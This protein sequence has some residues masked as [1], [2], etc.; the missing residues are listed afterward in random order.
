[1]TRWLRFVTA[2]SAA[3][4]VLF[5]ARAVRAEGEGQGDLD[6]ALRVKITANG[7]GDLNK[8]IELLEG[9]L[10]KGL[11]VENS[12]FA[13][14]V[15]SGSLLERATQ[16][17]GVVR[18]VP[19]ESLTDER[20]QRIRSL[21]ISDL[22]RVL[23]YDNPPVQATAMLAEILALPGGD[24][25]EALDLFNK[26]IDGE[27]FATMSV[28]EQTEALTHRA[29]LQPDAAKALADFARAVELAPN[30][31]DLRLARAQ[32]QFDHEDVDGALAE[33]AAV[34]EKTPNQAAAYLLQA[35]ILRTLKR[36]D[37][38]LKCLDKVAELAPQSPLPHMSRGEIF[39]EQ[40]QFEKA[41]EAFTRVLELQP[42]MDLALI[43]RAEAYFFADKLDE[44]LADVD[45]VLKD[46]PELALAH[47]LRAQV[48]AGKH[49]LGEAI[50][51]M[52]MLV[53]EL[54]GQPDVRMHLALYYQPRE[55]I[56]VYGEVLEID[57]DN[58]LALRS[59]GDAQLTVGDHAAAIAD[60]DRALK[61]EPEDSALLNNL[62]WVLS[63]SP[64]DKL[65]DGK[66]AIEL[67]TKAAE[68]TEF[69]KPHI[70]STL[71]A[72]YAEAGD[73]EK[74]REWSQKAVA[75]N[76]S[77]LEAAIKAD[78]KDE[79]KE[80]TEMGEQ[81]S[82]ELANY[83]DDKPV[84]ERQTL[85]EGSPKAAAEEAAQAAEAAARA[86]EAAVAS[87]G[88]NGGHAADS[89]GAEEAPA[90]AE[91]AESAAPDS[92]STADAAAK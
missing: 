76:Q 59:R 32:F 91:D 13:E 36:Y 67:G 56:A 18:S 44:A 68:L 54:P 73:F 50:S 40:G 81:L 46:H 45:A 79:I 72:A 8:V 6:E 43:R 31:P 17:A 39:R 33:V 25:A 53:D 80:L 77:N 75:L 70:L 37:E 20:I 14:Q 7:L 2:F 22:R 87:H 12:D 42:G 90:A 55:A 4:L 51:E 83:N 57:G 1:M 28:E 5:A 60:F 69:K 11:D 61:L 29:A 35:Q 66:R 26:L 86:A 52:K 38:A 30:N 23:T 3:A 82:K 88:L 10:E 48:L 9:A 27:S 92:P 34:V 84:R 24:A 89:D 15:L 62:S 85:E 65:R 71:A 64:D 19:E 58:Y 63:T 49:K 41:I 47:G 16:L 78:E 21:A 74:A